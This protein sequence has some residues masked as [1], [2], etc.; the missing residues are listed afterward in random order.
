MYRVLD[1]L[2]KACEKQLLYPL[3]TTHPTD[4][5]CYSI[6]G[7]G[8][9]Q[10]FRELEGKH[11]ASSIFLTLFGL[12]LVVMGVMVIRLIARTVYGDDAA[13]GWSQSA[14]CAEADGA[15]RAQD[16]QHNNYSQTV[17]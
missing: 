9:V 16:D 11:G 8:F 10:R 12:F 2:C 3:V 13:I 5:L 6:N 17:E 1:G 15:Y 7:D 4:P 14:G